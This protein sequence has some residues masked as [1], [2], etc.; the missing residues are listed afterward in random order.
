VGHPFA[1]WSRSRR[2]PRRARADCSRAPPGARVRS[3]RPRRSTGGTAPTRAGGA[4]SL[5]RGAGVL[6]GGGRSRLTEPRQAAEGAVRSPPPAEGV[7]P[8]QE[9]AS[10]RG[11]KRR[12]AAQWP[13]P[14]LPIQP[15]PQNQAAPYSVEAWP[16][17]STQLR[18]QRNNG[19]RP[20]G[21]TGPNPLAFPAAFLSAD[22]RGLHRP[23]LGQ[24]NAGLVQPSHNAITVGCTRVPSGLTRS[25]RALAGGLRHFGQSRRAAGSAGWQRAGENG[26]ALAQ[27]TAQKVRRLTL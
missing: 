6:E 5:S 10:G 19:D 24:V 27:V 14:L 15:S 3:A 7:A 9:S 20:P 4:A 8:G 25:A 11:R 16:A 1:Q 13:Q 2:R 12:P 26:K 23:R 17:G 21:G 22:E 18:D